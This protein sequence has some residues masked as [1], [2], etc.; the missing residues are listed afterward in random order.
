MAGH[1]TFTPLQIM[2][3]GVVIS[4]VILAQYQKKQSVK[5]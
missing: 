1:E 2:G 4:G 5:K 3:I